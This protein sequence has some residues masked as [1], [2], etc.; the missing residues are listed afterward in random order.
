MQNDFVPG[1]S[2]GFPDTGAF[3]VAEGD[4]SACD[5]AKWIDKVSTLGGMVVATRD[6]HPIDHCSF[7]THPSGKG[8]FPPHCVQGSP[9]SCFCPPIKEALQAARQ[10]DMQKVHIA[11]KGYSPIVD[12]F[13]GFPYKEDSIEGRLSCTESHHCAVDWTGAVAFKCSY[14][15]KDL[16]APPDVC[17]VEDRAQ[18]RLQEV[19][20]KN[21]RI[22]VCGLAFDFCVL[23]TALNAR[24]FFDEV[25][26]IYDLARAAYIPGLG[27]FDNF[28]TDPKE[29][30]AKLEKAGVFLVSAKDL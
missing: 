16:D 11:F 18:L 8:P 30:A 14:L 22:F 25:Y 17:S 3:A 21:G 27:Q 24:Q 12:S 2:F 1:D 28:L 10:R 7:N 4:K 13:G 15:D 26:I 6:Y 19:M 23:D 5:I 29:F 20:P 9:G